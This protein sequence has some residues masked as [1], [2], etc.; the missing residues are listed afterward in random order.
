MMEGLSQ[1]LSLS[2]QAVCIIITK[3]KKVTKNSVQV[4]K[5][6]SRKGQEKIKL[7]R[8]RGN[9]GNCHW[10][11]VTKDMLSKVCWFKPLILSTTDLY[12]SGTKRQTS[13]VAIHAQTPEP[14]RA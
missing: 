6:K 8:E 12:N 4:V 7:S 9:S 14:V 5:K 11:Y 10:Q 2:P 3:Y 1:V 13:A